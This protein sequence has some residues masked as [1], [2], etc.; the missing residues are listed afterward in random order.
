MCINAQD[1]PHPCRLLWF[2]TFQYYLTQHLLLSNHCNFL[3]TDVKRHYD[4]RDRMIGRRHYV[5]LKCLHLL[6]LFLL[7]MH[8]VCNDLQLF[9][10][11]DLDNLT[12]FIILERKFYS[13]IVVPRHS[14]YDSRSNANLYEVIM[15]ALQ[16]VILRSH[17]GFRFF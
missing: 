10:Y 5:L 4:Q 2:C 16:G 6:Q 17:E 13:I 11:C 12:L 15:S 9:W 3:E 14:G 1:I 7:F 8:K